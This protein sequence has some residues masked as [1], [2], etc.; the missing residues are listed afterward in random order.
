MV[1]TQLENDTTAA[2][3][4][5]NVTINMP[6]STYSLPSKNTKQDMHYFDKLITV[7]SSVHLPETLSLISFL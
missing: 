6:Q 5:T 2:A 4:M 7:L 3:I 1:M